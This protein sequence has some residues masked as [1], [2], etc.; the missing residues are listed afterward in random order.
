MIDIFSDSTLTLSQASKILP[1]GRNGA[2]PHL[3]TLIRWIQHG[4][5]A[6]DGHAVKL[7]AV[8]FGEKWLT[9]REAVARFVEEL[10]PR[11]DD[12]QLPRT[13]NRQRREAERASRELDKLGI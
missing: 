11:L 8:R 6:P 1:T 2:R 12:R 9:S 5:K 10:T 4:A 7:E 13:P 3:S